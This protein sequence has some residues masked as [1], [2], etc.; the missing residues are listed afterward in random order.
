MPMRILERIF[1]LNKEVIQYLLVNVKKKKL[2]IIQCKVI[3]REEE[4]TYRNVLL[5]A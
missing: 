2:F 4:E 1:N 3:A 5:S